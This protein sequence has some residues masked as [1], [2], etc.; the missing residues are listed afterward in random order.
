MGILFSCCKSKTTVNSNLDVI[1]RQ[2]LARHFC[3]VCT[4]KPHITKCTDYR[5]EKQKIPYLV[6]EVQKIPIYTTQTKSI[7]ITKHKYEE[8]SILENVVKKRPIEKTR[9]VTKYHESTKTH[10]VTKYRDIK[11]SR[12]IRKTKSVPHTESYTVY[13]TKSEPIYEWVYNYYGNGSGRNVFKGHKQS[14]V[15]KTEYRTIYK[16]ESYYDTEYYTEREP[17]TVSEPYVERIPYSCV[18]S[19][20]DYEDYTVEEYVTKTKDIPYTVYKDKQ[21]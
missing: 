20:I 7:P 3:L 11:K 18:E 1:H 17:Y 6:K 8:Y 13:T 10:E 15:P 2:F 14:R 21:E 5:E 4:H 12:Q 9:T 16:E 19:Y